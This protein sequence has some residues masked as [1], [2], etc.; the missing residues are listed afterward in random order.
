MTDHIVPNTRNMSS[1]AFLFLISLLLKTNYIADFS[2]KENFEY[3]FNQ[4]ITS[5]RLGSL[6]VLKDTWI[7]SCLSE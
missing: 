2:V 6:F 7:G 5:D 1:A 3:N 4:V